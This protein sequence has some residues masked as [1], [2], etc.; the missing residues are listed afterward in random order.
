MSHSSGLP[1]TRGYRIVV[2]VVGIVPSQNPRDRRAEKHCA[3]CCPRLL[4]IPLASVG[5][6]VACWL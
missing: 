2:E 3:P 4:L 1:P 6:P 5:P